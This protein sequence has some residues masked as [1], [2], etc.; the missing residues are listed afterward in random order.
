M[1]L[2]STTVYPTWKRLRWSATIALLFGGVEY[3]FAHLLSSSSAEADALHLLGDSGQSAVAA[4]FAYCVARDMGRHLETWSA[5]LQSA[6][7]VIAGVVICW[8]L[9]ENHDHPRDA[10]Y[11][12]LLGS[13]ATGTALLRLR[14]V[15]GDWG[16]PE[17]ARRIWSAITHKQGLDRFTAVEATHVILDVVTSFFVFLTG[18]L[19]LLGHEPD[20]DRWFAYASAVVAF[21]SAWVTYQLA[22]MGHHHADGC[23]HHHH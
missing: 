16:F 15:H 8:R 4:V 1:P 9:Y 2:I 7:L 6:C 19:M 13:A 23:D 18:S 3:I 12:F 5:Y 21:G 20:I 17:L 14:L 22:R 10:I 11:M